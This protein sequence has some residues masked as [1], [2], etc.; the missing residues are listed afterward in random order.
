MFKMLSP[1]DVRDLVFAIAF[2]VAGFLWEISSFTEDEESFYNS[3]FLLKY[4][5]GK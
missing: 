4:K 3:K 1:K 2:F 5:N